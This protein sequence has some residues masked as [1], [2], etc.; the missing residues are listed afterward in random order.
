MIAFTTLLG[1]VIGGALGWG[2]GTFTP[3]YYRSVFRTDSPGFNPVEVGIALGVT[4]GLLIGLGVGIIVIGILTWQ[5][6]RL[7]QQPPARRAT[8]KIRKQP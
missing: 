7:M 4:E 2:I 3:E 8:E 5:H 1:A 6:V